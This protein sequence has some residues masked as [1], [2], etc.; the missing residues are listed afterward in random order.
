MRVGVGPRTTAGIALAGLLL[1]ALVA[2]TYRNVRDVIAAGRWVEHTRSVLDEVDD[3]L[4]EVRDAQSGARAYV[5]TGDRS[6]LVSVE[7]ARAEAPA[8]AER[9]AQLVRDN[10]G[11]F[12]RAS[13]LRDF[14]SKHLA[15]SQSII[16]ARDMG[17]L[18][19]GAAAVAAG[20]GR[21]ALQGILRTAAEMQ[22]TERALL[23]ARTGGFERTVRSTLISLAMGA[24]LLF[25]FL[26]L[27]W[28]V[29]RLDLLKR[30]E[31][32]E[33]LR[34][35][36]AELRTTLRSIG[37]AVIAT[38][39]GG[40]ITF[41]NGVAEKLTG[42]PEAEALGRPAGEVFRIANEDTGTQVESPI[43]RVL[44][45]GVVAGLANHTVLLSRAG[46]PVP[47]ADSG[48]PILE[49]AGELK[50][51]VLVF[52]DITERRQAER[53]VQ[54]LA[55]IVS[56]SE[57][58][59][60]GESLDG[61]ITAWNA[62]AERLLGYSAQEV[63]GK[64]VSILEPPDVEES[65]GVRLSRV[66]RGERVHVFDTTRVSRD[67]KQVAVSL[68]LSPIRDA[69]GTVVGASKIIRDIGGRKKAELELRASEERFRVLSDN[70]ASLVWVAD[71]KGAVTH[72]N[73]RWFDHTGLSKPDSLGDAWQQA[74]FP[75]DAPAAVAKW[76]VSV[77]TGEPFE[78]DLRLRGADG[79][80]R[81][82]VAR[83]S[84]IRSRS[85]PLWV[86]T[87][88]DVDVLKNTA[89]ALREAKE[90]AEE[91][92]HAKDRF[93]AVLSHELRTPLTPA[94]VASQTL[95]RR[96]D[97]PDDVRQ[98]AILIR[99]NV[100]LEAL[101]VD[102]L[103]DLTKIA[104]GMVELRRQSVDLHELLRQV[105]EICR[106]DLLTRRQT[107]KLD[108]E[109]AEHHADADAARL[110]QVFW[111][112]I[113][114]AI[115]FTPVGGTISIASEC[116]STGRIRIHVRDTGIG[117]PAGIL[118]R[119]F[120][121]FERG[122]RTISPRV[123][124]L[125]LGLSI[126]RTL[127]E[128]H[129]GVISAESAGEGAGA[130]FTVELSAFVEK[131]IA[132]TPQRARQRDTRELKILLVEDHADTA[133]ALAQLLQEEGH[134]V[135][136][137]DSVA[138]AVEAFQ[139]SR[140]DLL[141]TDLG[142]PDGTGHELLSRLR[143]VAPVAGIVLSGYGMDADVAKS[144]AIGFAEHLT[145]PVQLGKLLRAV[146]EVARADDAAPAP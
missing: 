56:S 44:R 138:A 77:A 104:R 61:R 121:P 88:A 108:L 21:E 71:E 140:F 82:F 20:R 3:L 111:N 131:A 141:I 136:V 143:T 83:A 55:A 87:A 116:S 11:Q 25:T 146:N 105:I 39:A 81:W 46:Q 57:D 14:V 27:I 68:S 122:R 103:L 23:S 31:A 129:G 115:K 12:A 84:R 109:A 50:G 100:E 73:R 4:A 89:A 60:V 19:A 33:R 16:A 97:I 70:V 18:E 52:R 67:G 94:L 128:L 54:R 142:L 47:I 62:A 45:E 64:P 139:S 15:A 91:A 28:A 95:E 106:S 66:R 92:A 41:M 51:A 135:T 75:E 24:A 130:T 58:A 7:T 144:R 93:L 6:Y 37:D 10:P 69:E 8:Y 99:R 120:E 127:V 22:E 79:S 126:S 29:V 114:N 86:G 17:G 137:T 53:E 117:I 134:R 63:L 74:I 30:H 110:Q 118:P 113:K 112:L 98:S 90:A 124:G 101:L 9:I 59:I 107:L 1:A 145:K 49:T 119:I 38:D 65:T 78:A 42:W 2:V 40:R 96:R 76:Q 123:S 133:A 36:E 132:R 13:A 43:D 48:A 80:Y 35:S 102:D 85:G 26:G 125:G 32:Q 34:L 72:W 5:L